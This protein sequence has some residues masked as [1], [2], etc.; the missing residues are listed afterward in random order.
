MLTSGIKRQ[1][2][3]STLQL[4]IRLIKERWRS[5]W[6]QYVLA[7][8]LMVV[9]A[10][11]TAASAWLMSDVINKIF[12]AQDRVAVYWIPTV[13]VAIFV[14]KGLAG[15]FQ[16]VILTRV[17]NRLV[18]DTQKQMFDHLLG[19][20][21]QYYQDHPSSDLITKITYSA[22]SARDMI[23]M[24]FVS[25][26][27][28]LLT[29]IG[30][31]GVMVSQDPIMCA[32]S[33]TVGPIAFVSL[34][35]LTAKVKKAATS[36]VISLANIVGI[37]R[38]TTQ[39]IRIVK[40]FQLEGRLRREMNAAIDAVMRVG[41]KIVAT[42]ASVN[43]LIETLGGVAVALVVLYAGWRNL[44]YAETPGQFFAFVTAL[45]MASDPA[46]RLSRL[47]LQLATST[48]GVRIMYD[49]LDTPLN[50]VD[51]EKQSPLMVSKGQIVFE[52]VQFSY[53]AGTPVLKGLS[54]VAEAGKTT[55]L[56]GT[57]G[58]G[59]TTVLN[60]LQRFWLPQ[61]GR[62]L[63]DG[64]DISSVALQS[65]RCQITYVSQDVFLFEGTV[66]DNI[67]CGNAEAS[68]AMIRRAADQAYATGFIESLPKGFDT[69]VG[70]LGMQLSGGQRQRISMARAFLKDAPIIVLD[71]PTSALDSE[72]ERVIQTAIKELTSGKTTVVIAHRLATVL[73]AG[74][75]H[76]IEDGRVAES[77]THSALVRDGGTYA[78]LHEMQFAA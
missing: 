4:V 28:D 44:S 38:E 69:R 51:A 43:P 10:G 47:Q 52:G 30:L 29:L 20:N 13:I 16:E 60:L 36:E 5:Y 59:K 37:T 35:R 65:L 64:Q 34:R 77:G 63:I 24:L 72:S 62:I 18:A 7:I 31:L 25:L 22:G 33:M 54:L 57:S 17:G 12:V 11:T 26:G 58:G 40:S 49:L 39:G 53:N 48:I 32:I 61:G 55:A 70:E 45:L 67:R 1:E 21:V 27:R 56:V 66:R 73:K 76:V 41:N 71:E 75:I 2:L 42:Q 68:E 3:D 46:R 8:S 19:M 14:G 78:R 74:V 23:N 15:Y 6:L 9:V 50:D